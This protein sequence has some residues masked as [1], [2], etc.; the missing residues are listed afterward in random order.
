MTL[1][2]H[3]PQYI[4]CLWFLMKNCGT[5]AKNYIYN[6]AGETCEGFFMVPLI[7]NPF[8]SLSFNLKIIFGCYYVFLN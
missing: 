4:F 7:L 6:V 2:V 3:D 5:S 8:V 1:Y